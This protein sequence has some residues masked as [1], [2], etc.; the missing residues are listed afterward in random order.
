[1]TTTTSTD[2][3]AQLTALESEAVELRLIV[4]AGEKAR[5]RLQVL[6][7]GRYGE[8]AGIRSRME[9]A[10]KAER[11]AAEDATARRA[12]VQEF[13]AMPGEWVIQGVTELY[14]TAHKV[15]KW[16]TTLKFCTTSGECSARWDNSRLDIA[17]TFP[18]GVAAYRKAAKAARVKP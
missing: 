7:A 3:R 15:G 18:E 10:E 4:E 2:L 14:V 12:V 9:A 11:R 6:E 1:M 16:E 17:A 5:L 13:G 8:I